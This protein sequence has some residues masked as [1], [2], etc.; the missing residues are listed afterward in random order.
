[1]KQINRFIEDVQQLDAQGPRA[2]FGVMHIDLNGLKNINDCE[3]RAVGGQALVDAAGILDAAFAKSDVYRLGG[4]GFAVLSFSKDKDL[5]ERWVAESFRKLGSLLCSAAVSI[6]FA[7][8]PCTADEAV[9]LADGRMRQDKRR[10][11]GSC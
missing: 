8:V 10:F 11:Y 4:D 9:G 7:E 2:G 1:M 5:F 6:H 3:G